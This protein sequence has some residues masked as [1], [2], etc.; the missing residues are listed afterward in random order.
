MKHESGEHIGSP[1]RK[2]VEIG[3]IRGPVQADKFYFSKVLD[4]NLLL[5]G[6]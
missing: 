3:V 6:E 2:F 4:Y 5:Q 1:L